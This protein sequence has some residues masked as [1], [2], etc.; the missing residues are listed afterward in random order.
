MNRDCVMKLNSA[1]L[2]S[3]GTATAAAVAAIGT[4]GVLLLLVL[5][6]LFC[7]DSSRDA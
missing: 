2:G 3:E 5:L 1:P 4:A 7:A 6:L